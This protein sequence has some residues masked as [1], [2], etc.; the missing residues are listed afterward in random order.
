MFVHVPG[1]AGGRISLVLAGFAQSL[2][3][4]PMAV[5]LLHSA[6]A[7][8]RGRVMGVRMLA[9]YGLPLGLMAAGWLIERFGFAATASGYC[10]RRAAA[11]GGD[12]AALARGAVAAGRG[13]QRVPLMPPGDSDKK[14]LNQRCLAAIRS[15]WTPRFASMERVKE[16]TP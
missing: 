15:P 4:V 13:G 2:C 8:F 1:I 6:G 10:L 7:E 16:L 5:M 3:M 11:D 9:I 14:S 12:R